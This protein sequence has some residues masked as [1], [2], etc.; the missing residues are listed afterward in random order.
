M[1]PPA[2]RLAA[3]AMMACQNAR[4]YHDAW[5]FSS[6]LA[7]NCEGVI[8][9]SKVVRR[10]EESISRDNVGTQKAG[11]QMPVLGLPFE[12]AVAPYSDGQ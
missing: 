8:H 3:L 5:K 10:N 12:H 9:P 4:R 7:L 1:S 6:S 2:K 11:L